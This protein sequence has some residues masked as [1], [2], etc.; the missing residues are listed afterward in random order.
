VSGSRP[1]LPDFLVIGGGIAGAAAGGFLARY[2][3]VLLLEAE[4][5]P[6]MHATGRSAALFSEYYGNPV[7]R[8][9]TSASR[10]FYTVPPSGFEGVEPL[11]PRGSLVLA[12]GTFGEPGPGGDG[13]ADAAED[14]L[15][16]QVLHEAPNAAVPA[17]EVDR[18]EAL[19]LCPVLRPGAFR[20]AMFKPGA[21]DVDVDVV[22]R[23]FLKVL[24]TAGGRVQ[25]NARVRALRRTGGLWTAVTADG[26]YRAPIVVNAAGAWA[27]EIA[28]LAGVEQVGLVARRR[29]LAVVPAPEGVDPRGWP[30]IGDLAEGFYAKP[31]AGGL[32]VSPCDATPLPPGDVRP[33]DTA[34]ALGL[35]RLAAV[36]TLRPRRVSHRWAGLRSSAPDD[37][38]VVGPAAADSGFFWLAGLGG[39]GIQTAPAVGRLLAD[40]VAGVPPGP[41]LAALRPALDPARRRE[42]TVRADG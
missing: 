6:G 4:L 5:A 22:H 34:V 26:V 28:G 36:T 39:Y 15:F 31:E 21:A 27:D 12:C 13:A 11:R 32:L 1:D 18:D 9:L 42:P 14:A 2:G 19:R 25:V 3:R 40:L 30:M 35:D 20:R 38:P 23:H 29:T 33:D 7:V 8:A 17:V 41:D 24:R 10:A 16:E 37:V